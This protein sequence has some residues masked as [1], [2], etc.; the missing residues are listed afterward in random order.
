MAT[1]LRKMEKKEL[2]E[3]LDEKQRSIYVKANLDG[4]HYG[5]KERKWK[6]YRG[7]KKTNT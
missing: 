3:N 4:L 2:Q 7:M 6:R 1:T 5:K